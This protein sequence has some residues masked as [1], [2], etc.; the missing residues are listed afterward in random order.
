MKTLSVVSQKG[1]SGRTTLSVNLAVAAERAGL[2]CAIC[3]LDPQASGWKWS[4][5]RK[6]EAP[7][8]LTAVAE[9]LESI[10]AKA[11]AGGLDLLIIDSAPHA[12]RAA[13]LA[14]KAA[15]LVLVPTRASILDLD[16]LKPVL[17]LVEMAKR[18]ALAVLNGVSTTTSLDV[19][20]ARDAITARGVEL[21]ASYIHERV[22]YKRSLIDGRT[23]IE[24]GSDPKAV[25]EIETLFGA[26]V[27]RLGL[28]IPAPEVAA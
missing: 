3:D 19:D 24:V 5:R 4:Q 2:S 23:V 14:C 27:E 6:T 26:I 9:Q 16:A 10:Q 28:Q 18:P 7:E 17:E 25:R 11:T 22:I 8:V 21:H 13:L 12:D 1:G 15:D 20:E